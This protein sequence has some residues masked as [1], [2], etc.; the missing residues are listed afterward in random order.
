MAYLAVVGLLLFC[1]CAAAATETLDWAAKEYNP[2]NIRLGDQV[3][4]GKA[5]LVGY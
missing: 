5:K 1:Q 3:V 4:R 2:L